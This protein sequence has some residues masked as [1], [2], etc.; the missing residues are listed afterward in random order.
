MY[1]VDGRKRMHQIDGKINGKNDYVAYAGRQ[2]GDTPTPTGLGH[3]LGAL[4]CS[5]RVAVV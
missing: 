2:A 4:C 5:D 1:G 3:V